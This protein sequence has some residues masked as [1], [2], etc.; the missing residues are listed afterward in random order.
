[1][2][3]RKAS[4]SLTG[5]ICGLSCVQFV[6]SESQPDFKSCWILNGKLCLSDGGRALVRN[7]MCV[8]LGELGH[9]MP[10]Q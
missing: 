7:Q 10:K 8:H 9:L 6:V 2:A 1:M 3:S 5:G 4:F